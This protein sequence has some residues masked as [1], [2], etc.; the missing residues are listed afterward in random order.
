MSPVVRGV[1]WDD[2]AVS[3]LERLF[4]EALESL[5]IHSVA[6]YHS[7]KMTGPSSRQTWLARP[8]SS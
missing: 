6:G 5:H 8:V 2:F 4:G 3:S 1:G 7:V